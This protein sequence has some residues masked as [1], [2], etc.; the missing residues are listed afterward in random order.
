MQI[1]DERSR[2]ALH[3]ALSILLNLIRN[4]STHL[5]HSSVYTVL[6]FEEYIFLLKSIID[7]GIQNYTNYCITEKNQLEVKK[8]FKKERIE[9]D[10]YYQLSYQLVAYNHFSKKQHKIRI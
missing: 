9:L 4:F 8:Q 7:F 2:K 6:T 5:L 1:L 10:L 3:T